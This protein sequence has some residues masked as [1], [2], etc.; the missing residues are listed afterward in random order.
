[1]IRQGHDQRGAAGL[2]L[3]QSGFLHGFDDHADDFGRNVRQHLRQMV[4]VTPVRRHEGAHDFRLVDRLLNGTEPQSAGENH[5]TA[6]AAF[7]E[8][9]VV[10]HSQYF[11]GIPFATSLFHID[12]RAAG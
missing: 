3:P 9:D 12:D 11:H 7:G 10:E 4:R 6:V 5:L 8:H 1:M 2:T